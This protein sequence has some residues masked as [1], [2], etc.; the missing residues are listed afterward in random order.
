MSEGILG[1]GD[2]TPEEQAQ[3]VLKVTDNAAR[4]RHPKDYDDT[5]AP[6]IERAL[7]DEKLAKKIT[8]AAD[9][10][11]YAYTL[12]RKEKDGDLDAIL[13]DDSQSRKGIDQW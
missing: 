3:A 13:A 1:W 11:E 12:G 6:I 7:A 8:S 5:I 9:P 2:L 10:A 4:E